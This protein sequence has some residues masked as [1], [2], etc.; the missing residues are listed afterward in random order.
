M[1]IRNLQKSY[2]RNGICGMG[3]YNC[4]F[5][6][7]T[8]PESGWQP[9]NAIVFPKP[10]SQDEDW[11]YAVTTPGDIN[12]KWRGDHFVDAL[13]ALIREQEAVA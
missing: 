11:Y 12:Q 5:E 8:G 3:F 1:E 6:A 13:W 2:H 7:D 10:E 9:F 4:S